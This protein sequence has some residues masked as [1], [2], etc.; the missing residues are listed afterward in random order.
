VLLIVFMITAPLLTN[1]VKLELPQATSQV[2]EVQPKDITLS[3]TADGVR[4]WNGKEVD[5]AQLLTLMQAAAKENPLPELQLQVDKS[6]EYGEVAMLMAQA[7]QQ[8][9]DKLAFVS[10]PKETQ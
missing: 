9:L 7:S 3:V 2:N 8:G 4:H 10:A 5:E 6:V 1:A